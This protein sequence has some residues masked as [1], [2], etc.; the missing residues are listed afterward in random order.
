MWP[1]AIGKAYGNGMEFGVRRA[2]VILSK[3]GEKF[4]IV[5]IVSIIAGTREVAVV[6]DED[7]GIGNEGV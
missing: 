3:P 2:S 7:V 6:C 1:I 4:G 5:E